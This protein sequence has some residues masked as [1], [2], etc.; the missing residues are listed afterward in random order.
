MVGDWPPEPGERP[1]QTGHDPHRD[2]RRAPYDIQHLHPAGPTDADHARIAAA[3]AGVT[4][5]TRVL[6]RADGL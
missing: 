1:V 2:I 5:G 6:K 4:L 3:H